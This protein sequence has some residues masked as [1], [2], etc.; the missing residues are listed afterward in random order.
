M[1]G[2]GETGVMELEAAG[3]DSDDRL[4]LEQR[5][6]YADADSGTFGECGKAAPAAAHLVRGGDTAL[7]RC[8]VL[9]F[10][11]ITAADKPACGAE[12]VAVAID[13]FV[14]VDANQRNM[15][16][17]ALLDRDRLDPRTVSTADRVTEGDH[18]I[19]LSDLLGTV[20]RREHA[21]DLFAHG[22]E[23][24]EAVRVHQVVVGRFA[25]DGPE[26]F[27]KLGLDVRVLCK[28]PYGESKRHGCCLVADKTEEKRVEWRSNS[29]KISLTRM[30]ECDRK[31][32]GEERW[33]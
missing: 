10:G 18:I 20:H 15:D 23:V 29:R 24:G 17:L 7:S 3:E 12:D 6:L 5:E 13:G 27:T 11:G 22:I 4:V 8:A 28:R 21:H 32:H 19:L 33:L 16:D 1:C 9:G 14:T 25:S 31:F 26:F 30:S 2:D